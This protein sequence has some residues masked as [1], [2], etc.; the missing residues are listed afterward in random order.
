[1]SHVRR[2]QS[3]DG[4]H[5]T[6]VVTGQIFVAS[7]EAFIAGFEAAD[8]PERVAI[9]VSQAHVRDI[10]A[11]DALGKVV[12]RF[13]RTGVT[14]IGATEASQKLIGRHGLHHHSND[15]IELTGDQV[16]WRS[17]CDHTR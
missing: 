16:P 3:E 6:C 7:T 8:V 11:V 1:M 2:E 14:V 12:V 13:C 10:S 17:Q 9:D 4:R 5:H 15:Q